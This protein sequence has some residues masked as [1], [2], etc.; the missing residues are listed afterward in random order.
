MFHPL[1]IVGFISIY[2]TKKRF[3][4]VHLGR[5]WGVEKEQKTLTFGALLK[6]AIVNFGDHD[7]P[8]CSRPL[9]WDAT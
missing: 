8:S 5:G 6:K 1:N 7:R 2:F 9:D 4:T 3:S